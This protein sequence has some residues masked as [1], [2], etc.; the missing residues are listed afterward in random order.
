[1]LA[2]ENPPCRLGSQT[3]RICSDI[4]LSAC[5]NPN[6]SLKILLLS[7][8]KSEGGCGGV[9]YVQTL[10]GSHV[11]SPVYNITLTPAFI[12]RIN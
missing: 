6:M 11:K 9:I 8:G 3:F 1:M 4:N 2:A 12:P 10:K 5:S 7:G